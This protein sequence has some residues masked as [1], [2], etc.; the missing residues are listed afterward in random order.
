MGNFL[1]EETRSFAEIVEILVFKK[2]NGTHSDGEPICD[3]QFH[4]DFTRPTVAVSL[5]D[6]SARDYEDYDEINPDDIFCK[7]V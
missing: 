1:A 7:S 4:L 3:S 6:P 2:Q 5:L